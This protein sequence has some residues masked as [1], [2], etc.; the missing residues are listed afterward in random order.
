MPPAQ[1]KEHVLPILQELIVD[2]IP[3][4]RFNVCKCIKQLEPTIKQA[5]MV[6]DIQGV[7]KQLEQEQDED[8]KYYCQEAMSVF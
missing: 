6:G 1:F 7:L 3:N 4:V 5:Q 2:P 8:V